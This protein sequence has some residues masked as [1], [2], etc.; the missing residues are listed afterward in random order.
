MVAA[1]PET[2]LRRVRVFGICLI[3]TLFET[4]LNYNNPDNYYLFIFA[5]GL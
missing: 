1:N 3:I 5:T 4:S 2:R